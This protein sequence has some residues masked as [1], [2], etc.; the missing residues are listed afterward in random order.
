MDKMS[1]LEEQIKRI[2]K[3]HVTWHDIIHLEQFEKWIRETE[4]RVLALLDEEF[5]KAV[6]KRVMAH[7]SK[8]WEE[9]KKTHV[10]VEKEKLLEII[11]CFPKYPDDVGGMYPREIQMYSAD[12][13]KVFGEIK[14]LLGV[15]ARKK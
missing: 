5:D 12:V 3:D 11:S 15:K 7:A 10:I 9:M 2:F 13:E 6:T 1:E 14:K 4:K 8:S